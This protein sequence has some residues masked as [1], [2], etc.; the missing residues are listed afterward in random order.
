[1]PTK[2]HGTPTVQD[3]FVAMPR[4]H[5]LPER[6]KRYANV[7]VPVSIGYGQTNSQPYT[8]EL[9]LEW[10][11]V[12][13]GNRVLD[14]GS[15]SGWTTALLAHLVG[16]KGQVAG[17]EQVPELVEFGRQNC[18][19]RGLLNTTFHQAKRYVLGWPPTAPY[20]R[21]L[22][23]ATASEMPKDLLRQLKPGGKMI[24][25]INDDVVEVEKDEEGAI[26]ATHHR[27]FIFEPLV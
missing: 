14:V 18:R 27:G 10:L 22:V 20:D 4:R 19:S 21:I 16:P 9:M 24:I 26:E 8:V 6:A 2:A 1:M 5:F 15:G 25:P 17:V 12:E 23:S 11:Q 3:A 13:P 7:N